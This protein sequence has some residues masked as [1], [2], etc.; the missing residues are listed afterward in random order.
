[1]RSNRGFS[2]VE[3]IVVLAILALLV[4]A[5]ATGGFGMFSTKVAGRADGKGNTL[6]GRVKY[7]AKDVECRSNLNQVR[8][9]VMIFRST[10]DDLPPEDITYTRL[11]Q[12][13]Y[14]CPVGGEPFTYEPQSGDVKCPHPGHEKY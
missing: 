9:A 5:F 7:S 1:M 12:D 3:I 4:G 8:Q 10:N 2:L 14:K 11:G 6:V 13:F